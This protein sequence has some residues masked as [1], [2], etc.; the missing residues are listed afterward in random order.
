MVFII[1]SVKGDE[2]G[3][4]PKLDEVQTKVDCFLGFSGEC[5]REVS[6]CFFNRLKF[7]LRVNID[8]IY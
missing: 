1:L 3:T 2:G 4:H 5:S 7:Y 8:R 6:H